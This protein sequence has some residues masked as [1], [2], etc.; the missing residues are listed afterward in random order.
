MSSA[1]GDT[2][3]RL[4]LELVEECA[5]AREIGELRRR[6][7]VGVRRLVPCDVAHTVTA[8]SVTARSGRELV[9]TVATDPVNGLPPYFQPE[10][11][12][13][14]HEH[15]VVDHQLGTGDGRAVMTSD[16]VSHREMRNRRLYAD[17]LAPLGIQETLAIS[18]STP[19]GV[20]AL[21]IHGPWGGFSE[22]ER[23]LL[24]AVRPFVARNIVRLLGPPE[25][26]PLSAREREVVLLV[27][28]GLADKQIATR[29][30]ISRGT[31]SKHLE[32]AYRKLGVTNRTAAAARVLGR[33]S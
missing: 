14:R 20:A 29:M 11:L 5:T 6:V 10:V 24:N 9:A 19:Q 4:A 13:L 22:R 21:C 23:S 27:A 1:L 12:R 3:L 30:G 17:L 15:P 26:E 7:A 33:R 16:F 8:R 31:V 28:E 2:D 18:F 32:H 25:E